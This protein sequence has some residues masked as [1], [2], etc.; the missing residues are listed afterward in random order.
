VVDFRIGCVWNKS[1]SRHRYSNL[2]IQ[3]YMILVMVQLIFWV[4]SI[5]QNFKIYKKLNTER[6]INSKNRMVINESAGCLIISCNEIWSFVAWME[7]LHDDKTGMWCQD[8]T[9]HFK[10]LWQ[11]FC[12]LLYLFADIGY[13]V[14]WLMILVNL[15]SNLYAYLNG[16][17][18]M[19]RDVSEHYTIK[20]FYVFQSTRDHHNGISIILYYRNFN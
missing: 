13:Y 17:L 11:L 10:V 8:I 14:Y 19:R 9:A 6:Q 16:E 5:V 12:C 1:L 18:S 2:L 7:I 4:S 20:Y 15:L 3:L